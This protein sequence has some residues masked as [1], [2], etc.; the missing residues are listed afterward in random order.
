MLILGARDLSIYIILICVL[1][2][3]CNYCIIST[4]SDH[5]TLEKD[6]IQWTIICHILFTMFLLTFLMLLF[7]KVL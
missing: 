5:T 6:I 4:C 2:S 1:G 3:F 7:R